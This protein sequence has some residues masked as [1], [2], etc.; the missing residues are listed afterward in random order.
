LHH[1]QR[2]DQHA[3]VRPGTQQKGVLTCTS[4]GF[5]FISP[6]R[7]ALSDEQI[8]AYYQK[9]GYRDPKGKRR[10]R[11]SPDRVKTAIGVKE[12]ARRRY[13]NICENQPRL[14]GKKG[15]VLDIGTNLGHFLG[16]MKEDGWDAHGCEPDKEHAA[17]GSK[18]YG[19][20]IDPLLY[21]FT[22]YAERSFDLIC[23]S[24]V[25]EHCADARSVVRKMRCDLKDDGRIYIEVPT[26]DRPYGGD[27]DKFFWAE[28]LNYFSQNTLNALLIQ[29]GYAMES[30]GYF[31]DFLWVVA[32][33]EVGER[34]TVSFPCDDPTQVRG[35]VL[36]QQN[37]FLKE[38][39]RQLEKR[40]APVMKIWK[41]TRKTMIKGLK[42]LGLKSVLRRYMP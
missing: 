4:C 2:P 37:L 13:R 11:S 35:N 5:V 42:S 33:K 19:I 22:Q 8:Q 28:H 36:Y 18:Y 34:G 39:V 20:S 24:H 6:R 1:L 23:L 25:L 10:D 30:T 29:E 32:K 16:F 14:V 26:I 21:V 41:G 40:Y 12:R 27:L 38:K 15:R 3:G 31:G 9:G 7:P 17:A